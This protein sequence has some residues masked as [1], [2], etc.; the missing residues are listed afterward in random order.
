MTD[1]PEDEVVKISRIF[2][3]LGAPVERSE[4]MALQLLKRAGQIATERGVP[5]VEAVETLLKQVVEARQGA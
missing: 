3:N 5:K 4:V 1:I 2:V